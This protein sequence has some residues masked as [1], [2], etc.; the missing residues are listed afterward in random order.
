MTADGQCRSASYSTGEPYCRTKSLD[1]SF[2]QHLRDSIMSFNLQGCCFRK[3]DH[4]TNDFTSVT[5]LSSSSRS[6][7]SRYRDAYRLGRVD[8]RVRTLLLDQWYLDGFFLR[9]P[10]ERER[11]RRSEDHS[12]SSASNLAISRSSFARNLFHSSGVAS[13]P[14]ALRT[15]PIAAKNSEPE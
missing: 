6:S 4:L 12:S 11:S 9:C 8:S 13:S 14:T 2:L 1:N 5:A 7:F 3:S 15:L 10:T